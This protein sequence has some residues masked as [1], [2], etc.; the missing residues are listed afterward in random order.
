MVSAS[1]ETAYDINFNLYKKFKNINKHF[2]IYQQ[3]YTDVTDIL[4]YDAG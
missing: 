3:V 2:L 1:G 4:L